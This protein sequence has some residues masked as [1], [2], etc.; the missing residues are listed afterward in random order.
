VFVLD[1]IF[2]GHFALLKDHLGKQKSL[3][4]FLKPMM[5]VK[6][7]NKRLQLTSLIN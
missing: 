6:G 4:A 7:K 2:H 3:L 5:A 1:F